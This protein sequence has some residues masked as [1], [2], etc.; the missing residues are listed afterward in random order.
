M[1][2]YRGRGEPP[3]AD[4]RA[5]LGD[6][7]AYFDCVQVSRDFICVDWEVGSLL[8]DGEILSLGEEFL[9]IASQQVSPSWV[10]VCLLLLSADVLSSWGAT[11]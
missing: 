9:G 6:G 8:S 5:A 7:L 1:F 11:P 4:W 10:P 2:M 3:R